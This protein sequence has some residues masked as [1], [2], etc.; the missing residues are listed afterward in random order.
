MYLMNGRR[1]KVNK[2]PI[3]IKSCERN[4]ERQIACRNTWIDT[5]DKDKYLPLFLIGRKN[6]PSEIVGDILYLDCEDHYQGL[7]GKMKAYYK[8][9]LDNTEVSHFW[10]CDDDSYINFNNFNNFEEYKNY[11]YIGSF[12]YGINKIDNRGGY[13]SGCGMCVS[14][15]AAELCSI[16][17][18]YIAS[19]DDVSIG[20]ILNEHMSDVKKFDPTTIRAWSYCTYHSTLLI[21]HYIHKGEGSLS[22]FTESMHKMHSLYTT[23]NFQNTIIKNYIQIGSHVGYDL[24][25]HMISQSTEKLNV[26]LIEPNV[27]LLSDLSKNYNPLKQIHDITI[28]AYGISLSDN[29]IFNMHIYPESGHA[30]LINRKSHPAIPTTKK[31]ITTTLNNLCEELSI[32]DIELLFIDTEGF[33]YEILNSIDLSK[34]NI[35]NIIF[36]PWPYEDD[37]LNYTYR[38]GPKFFYDVVV[39]KYKNYLL[40]TVPGHVDYKFTKII[41]RSSKNDNI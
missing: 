21:G 37:D 16:H 39:P 26:I 4:S 12:I 17:L 25:H 9:A 11:D 32:V 30:S 41:P 1:S 34:I 38:S 40:D 20:N 14:R 35:N 31:I 3:G 18:P 33:D 28:L 24:F 22:T 10:S 36:E 19:D 23:N 2:I 15:K 8:W 29:K 5:L 27:D 6:Q 7:S 13:T